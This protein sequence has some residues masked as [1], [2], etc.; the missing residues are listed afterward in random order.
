[1]QILARINKTKIKGTENNVDITNSV[2]I[3]IGTL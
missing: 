3:F 1:M 2:Y